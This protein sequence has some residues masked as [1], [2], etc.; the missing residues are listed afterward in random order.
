MVHCSKCTDKLAKGVQQTY[1]NAAELPQNIA[2]AIMPNY[3]DAK[4]VGSNNYMTE[5]NVT[6][7]TER[8]ASIL[9]LILVLDSF[10]P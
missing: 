9:R 1:F 3:N 2:V 5:S 4:Y 6:E 7:M 10:T 8:F